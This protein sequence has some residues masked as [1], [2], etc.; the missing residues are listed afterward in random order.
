MYFYGSYEPGG[1]YGVWDSSFHVLVSLSTTSSNWSQ[2]S[3]VALK[4][5]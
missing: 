2:H 4:Q 1:S 5:R 3:R